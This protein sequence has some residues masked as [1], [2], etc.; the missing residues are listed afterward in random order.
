MDTDIDVDEALEIIEQVL[1]SRQL[2]PTERFVL[3][4]SWDRRK[5]DEMAQESSY[6]SVYIKE[7][8]SKLWHDL[9]KV[10]GER[11]TK[12]NLHLSIKDYLQTYTDE[13]KIRLEQELQT[14]G[15]A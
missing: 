3:R 1:L 5:Y 13:R 10:L 12:K 2:S 6:G 4:Q 9:S 7:L 15:R 14:N 11:V 8:G